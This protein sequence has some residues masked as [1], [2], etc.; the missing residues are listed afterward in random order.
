MCSRYVSNDDDVVCDWCVGLCG[1]KIQEFL[2]KLFILRWFL[3]S[4]EWD[5]AIQRWGR[6]TIQNFMIVAGSRGP[7]LFGFVDAIDESVIFIDVGGKRP[8]WIL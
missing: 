4:L 6:D 7:L 8:C 2:S 5:F 3:P 1:S